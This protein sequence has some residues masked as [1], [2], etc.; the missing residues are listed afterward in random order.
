[1]T[2]VAIN[3]QR[4]RVAV[5]IFLSIERAGMPGLLRRFLGA[6]AFDFIL[7]LAQESSPIDSRGNPARPIS[8]RTAC[9]TDE[10]I[11]IVQGAMGFIRARGSAAAVLGPSI[12]YLLLSVPISV[13]PDI[14]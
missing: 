10:S 11:R 9:V 1:M 4:L 13:S 3:T 2:S 7:V 6:M 14:E 12:N 8:T 5:G